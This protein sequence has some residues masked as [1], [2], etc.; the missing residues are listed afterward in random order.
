M[1]GFCFNCNTRIESPSDVAVQVDSNTFI[2]SACHSAFGDK[3]TH[4]VIATLNAAQASKP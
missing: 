2:C 4:E 3:L 1:V